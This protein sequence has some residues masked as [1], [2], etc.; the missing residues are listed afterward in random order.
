VKALRIQ[1]G[2]GSHAFDVFNVV[3]LGL[4]S[5]LTVL[6]FI[7][8]VVASFTPPEILAKSDFVLFPSRLSL[9]GY[10]Y[11]F[12]TNVVA[13]SLI[14]STF[15]TIVGTFFSIIMT[16]LM[17]YPLAHK[18]LTGRKV[19]MLM[20]I[21]TIMFNGG[22]VP[23]YIIVQKLHLLNTYMSLILPGAISVFSLV[24]FKSYFQELPAELEE[25]A[26][27]DGYNDLMILFK[28]I[29]PSSKPLLATFTVM[30]GVTYW[31]T[32]FS[33][34]LYLNDSK[35]W[36]VQLVL[37]QVMNSSSQIGDMMESATLI[38]PKTIQMCV[39]TIA[40]FPILCAYPFLQ[41]YFSQGMLLG[42][43]KG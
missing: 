22:L 19:I 25:S 11:V 31:N 42:S 38:Q 27:L 37:R 13:R 6:P 28:I 17:A 41:K 33:A 9:E 20:V 3:V 29:L 30:F 5:L 12:S 32:W 39:I 35:M 1:N 2:Y 8:I 16:V 36:P 7:H 24:I 43:V 14:V 34:V 18:T 10:E 4:V 26:R 15:I 40:T 21:F 23:T